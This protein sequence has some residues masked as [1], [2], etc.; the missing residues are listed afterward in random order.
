MS[1]YQKTAK[2]VVS[3]F[4]TSLEKGL[5]SSQAKDRIATFG[6][7][8][9]A[10]KR[11]ETL[12][13]IFVR[14]FTSPLI[15]IL[16]F[17]AVLVLTLGAKIDALVIIAV[18]TFNAVIGT[19]QEGKARNSLARLKSLTKHKAVVRRNE[20][21]VLIPAE[22]IVPGDILI[23]HE[24]DRI[25]A[26]ARIIACKG[27]KV[28]ESILTGEAE[29]VIKTSDLLSHENLVVGDQKNMVFAGT[30]VVGGSSECVVVET[31]INSQIGK[32]SKELL[33]TAD[34][35]LP[36]AKKVVKLTHFIAVSVF[37]IAALTFF[38][39]LLRGIEFAEI[40]GAV[41]GLSVS[42]VPPGVAVG[43]ASIFF[44][45]GWWLG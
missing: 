36:L 24:G 18:I 3:E 4:S 44:G 25:L 43:G 23:L 32:I 19:I 5:S 11:Q 10:Q 8:V 41:I 26:D 33:E 22:E 31:G 20:E 45:G 13:D 30:S 9:L 39:G 14:Q 1:Y 28:N 21:E 42:I 12:F 29:A 7:N 27:L 17:A 6:A 35:P 40:L 38:A 34:V 15:Y 2:E 16:I 37:L